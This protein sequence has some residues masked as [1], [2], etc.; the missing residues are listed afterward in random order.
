ML[1]LV[2]R[3]FTDAQIAAQLSISP[4]TVKTHLTSTYGKIQVS[5]RSAA[6]RYAIEHQFI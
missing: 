5:S 1:R 2:A 6:M 4:R 3:G